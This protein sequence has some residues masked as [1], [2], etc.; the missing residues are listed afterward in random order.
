MRSR[1]TRAVVVA[2]AG[3]A[4]VVL[5]CYYI[6][7]LRAIAHRRL[8]SDFDGLSASLV[9]LFTAAGALMVGH[10]PTPAS[11]DPGRRRTLGLAG[12]AVVPWFFI[13][14][15]LAAGIAPIALPHFP[16]AGEAAARA[17]VGLIGASLV[18]AAVISAGTLV[19]RLVKW[20]ST[21]RG[22][23]L[24][25][26]AVSGVLVVSYGSLLLA[27]LRVYRPWTVA[28]LIGIL[29]LA[30]AY[31]APPKRH[32]AAATRQ[33]DAR[34]SPWLVLT[35]VALAYAFITALAPEKEFDALWYH[36]QLPRL[37]LDAGRPVDVI[38]EYVSLYPLTWD[39]LF[40]AGL[41]LGGGVGA[42]LLHFACLPFLGTLVWLAARRYL[43]DAPAAAAVALVVTTPTILW[44]A[45][46]AYVD[47]ALALHGAAACY[48]L[49][50]YAEEGGR[51]WGAAAALQFGAAAATKHLGIILALVALGLYVLAAIRYSRGAAAALRRALL[52][53]FGA[54]LVTS[55]WYIRNWLASGNPVF[56]EM[57]SMFGASPPERWNVVVERGLAHFKAHFGIG[58]SVGD[59]IALPWDVTVHGAF[60]GGS[61]G[62]LFL[63]LLP[64]V[65][66]VRGRRTALPWLCAG[67]AAYLAFWASPISS[68]QMRFLMPIVPALALVAAAS[69]EGLTARAADAFPHGR[70]V[71]T[72]AVLL[73]GTMNLPPFT[74]FHE[75]DRAAW[76]GWLTHVVRSAPVGVV[77]GR[78]S[79]AAYLRREVPSYS[80]WQAINATS[81]PD[82]RILTFTGGDRFYVRRRYVPHDSALATPVLSATA[83]ES[84]RAADALRNLGITHVLFDRR[85]LARLDPDNRAVASP[86][87]QRGCIS[88]YDDRR[89]WLCRIDYA[90]LLPPLSRIRASGDE[91]SGAR[92]RP[93]PPG[94]GA[95]TWLNLPPS[96][97]S[98]SVVR[99]ARE[100]GSRADRRS[101]PERFADPR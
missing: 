53:G 19:L 56:P 51:G 71:L 61:L 57:F 22:E 26:A 54:A 48:A 5:A 21:S 58:R 95:V 94:G 77:I 63:V 73:L 93:D 89:F 101:I 25:F 43:P 49:A 69:L 28:V 27:I 24:V 33:P 88:D 8:P 91:S 65:L 79:E 86:E 78:E 36:L 62:P 40:G 84:S 72:A 23:N 32:G 99:R 81:P 92:A 68:Y 82:A 100:S 45:G 13:W 85:E 41:T 2:W 75:A 44:E 70:A 59:L 90:R 87:F 37:W 96:A 12:I 10:G 80:A 64:G 74:R 83:E 30:G 20:H 66:L 9:L 18:G 31:V 67:I 52:V 50:R 55:P 34:V 35:G 46:T 14:P 7:P 17:M 60:F 6:E 97:P 76:D 15:R 1:P 39:L 16:F 4:C 38:E 3:W 47:L 98:R 29:C 11:P 42:K